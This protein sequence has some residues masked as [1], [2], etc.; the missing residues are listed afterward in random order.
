MSNCAVI[1]CGE[2]PAQQV[3]NGPEASWEGPHLRTFQRERPRER[4][5]RGTVRFI[6][7][8][9]LIPYLTQSHGV[10]LRL[11]QG[12]R[13]P[14]RPDSGSS[15]KKQVS[16]SLKSCTWPTLAQLQSQEGPGRMCT[17]ARSPDVALRVQRGHLT[18]APASLPLPP[19][20]EKE[21]TKKTS[22]RRLL[23]RQEQ[24]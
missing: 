12:G 14:L 6:P 23:S 13:H 9:F 3:K 24:H 8:S 5:N 11:C 19:K 20:L 22:A 16:F 7:Q 2:R 1:K 18:A 10:A 4:G 21:K 15:R 17:G